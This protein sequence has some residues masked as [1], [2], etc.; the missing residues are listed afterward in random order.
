MELLK[1]LLGFVIVL[2]VATV[3]AIVGGA[4]ANRIYN[5]DEI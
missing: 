3:M 2:I 5:S 4:M 1:V